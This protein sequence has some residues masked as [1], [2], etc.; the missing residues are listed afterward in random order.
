MINAEKF[1]RQEDRLRTL[2]IGVMIVFAA[3]AAFLAWL[4]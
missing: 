2:G 3:I 1:N 4:G